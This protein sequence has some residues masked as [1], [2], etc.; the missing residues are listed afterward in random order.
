MEQQQQQQKQPVGV[1]QK[2]GQQQLKQGQAG[3]RKMTLE[4]LYLHVSTL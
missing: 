3:G 4:E 1:A 2:Q